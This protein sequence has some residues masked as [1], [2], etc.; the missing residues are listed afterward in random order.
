MFA[1][2]RYTDFLVNEIFPTGEVVH[3]D[4][5]KGPSRKKHIDHDA[6]PKPEPSG[7]DHSDHLAHPEPATSPPAQDDK[8]LPQPPD[9]ESSAPDDQED[10]NPAMQQTTEEV[11]HPSDPEAEVPPHKRT[12]ETTPSGERKTNVSV[13][14]A[15]SPSRRKEKTILRQTSSGLVVV[16]EQDNAN[17]SFETHPEQLGPSQQ[18][19]NQ[20][21]QEKP[22]EPVSSSTADWQSYAKPSNGFQVSHPQF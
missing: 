16:G 1:R 20:A 18:A 6:S 3:L 11:A 8:T 2:R 22:R 10:K 4:S 13:E 7:L 12:T 14:E 5:L 17:V 15:G 19:E 21:P 9:P